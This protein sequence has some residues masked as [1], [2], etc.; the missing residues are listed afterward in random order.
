[1]LSHHLHLRTFCFAIATSILPAAVAVAEDVVGFDQV[2][3][4]L[5]KRCVT[6][7]NPDELRGELD[8]KELTAIRA[9]SA[10]GDVV[11]SG[12]PGAS[13]LYTTL[14]HLEDPVM[15]P[16]SPQIPAREQ[17][18]IRHWI[19]GGLAER[20]GPKA[21]SDP[22]REKLD[23]NKPPTS[24]SGSAGE[25]VKV[26]MNAAT[27]GSEA[28]SEVS[29]KPSSKTAGLVSIRA[30]PQAEALTALDA[31]PTLDLAAVKGLQQ[32]VLFKPSTGE[33]LNAINI[34]AGDVSDLR[35]SRD[36]KLLMVAAG[37]A[38]V[39]GTVTAF[40]VV[41]GQRVWQVADETDSILTFDLARD[42]HMLAV[43]GP[44]K[45]VRI[46]EVPSGRE[47]HAL[48]KHT[49][50]VLSV[51]FSPDGLLLA[52]S[53]RFGGIFVWEPIQGTVFHGLKDHVGA[54]HAI[55]WD[56]DSE[57]LISGGEDAKLRTWNLHH[58]ELTS[59]WDAQV[60]AILDLVRGSGFIAAAGR[61]GNVKVW[62]NPETMVARCEVGEQ[63]ET[64]ARTA[65]GK[66]LIV[67]DSRGQISVMKSETLAPISAIEL[68][69]DAGAMQQLLVRLD[70]AEQ[71]YTLELKSQAL[72]PAPTALAE[73]RVNAP[74]D[75]QEQSRNE[76]TV[77][78]E[79]TS[80]RLNSELTAELEVNRRQVVEVEELLQQSNR[81]L[82]SL[83]QN[84]ERLVELLRQSSDAQTELAQQ[85]S[86]QARI[87]E[88][89]R[90]RTQ[91][92]EL[93]SAK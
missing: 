55:T 30:L 52:S 81:V 2:K 90:A 51:R 59:S 47:L 16:N 9:G 19:E 5:R 39:S 68:P 75:I 34:P 38:A 85:I 1:M 64:L 76:S 74:V 62:S 37:Q 83:A 14:A 92:L 53:D 33:L 77:Q 88:S 82:S 7:H 15:P 32:A 79:R 80:P 50:W 70:K 41:T 49:D 72:S 46:Y 45:T 28:S 31:H 89:L 18:I 56:V 42:G 6:C 61:S 20:T 25:S 69:K 60:G 71:R 40:D 22:A 17:D 48:K 24:A 84:N 8:L 23:S 78:R 35:F 57:T 66:H 12:D 67:G 11:V 36:G 91:Q 21:E 27:S 87:L 44:S 29:S 86:Q 54:V 65:D 4:I 43:G 73:S 26:A 58:G 13:L 63:A 3:P 10:S 93:G